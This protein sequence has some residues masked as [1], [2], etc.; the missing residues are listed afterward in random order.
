MSRPVTTDEY[1]TPELAAELA[2]GGGVP[3]DCYE[4]RYTNLK[5]TAMNDYQGKFVKPERAQKKQ[6]VHQYRPFDARTTNQDDFGYKGMPQRRA[7][8]ILGDNGLGTGNAP[9]QGET[10]QKSDFRL[11][12][13]N[14][15]PPAAIR[16]ARS[17]AGEDDDRTFETEQARSYTG[18]SYPPRQ[19]RAPQQIR[20]EVLPFQGTTTNQMDFQ[21]WNSRPAT[22]VD[23]KNKYRP[24]DDDR[25]WLT[26][27]K[28]E[29]IKKPMDGRTQSVKEYDPC[30]PGTNLYSFA[31]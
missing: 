27:A 19:S 29:Y 3:I 2:N 17:V 15:R 9:F 10:T 12:N 18:A 23:R 7:P 24:R 1:I 6:Y 22:L 11:W 20:T 25:S 28:S 30:A 14:L 31:Q 5:T 8:V 4:A 21:K 26:E 16:P 13:G